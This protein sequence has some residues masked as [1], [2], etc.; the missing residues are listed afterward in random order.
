M[1]KFLKY[2]NGFTLIEIFVVIFIISIIIGMSFGGLKI[3]Q[4]SMRLSA[5]VSDLATDL[6]YIQQQA[7]SEQFNYGISFFIEINEYQI[8]K[9]ITSTTTQEI[10]TK[11]LAQ[12]IGFQEIQGFTDNIVVFN[13]YGSVKE[14]GSVS[15]TNTKEEIKIINIRPSGFIKIEE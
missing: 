14:A 8:L 1:I 7:V 6:H 15:L 11:S 2:H 4:S 9:Y 3:L 13:P 5:T 10:S 12:G